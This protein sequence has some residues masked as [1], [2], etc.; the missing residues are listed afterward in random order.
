MLRREAARRHE[1]PKYDNHCRNLTA[2]EIKKKLE[3]GEQYTIRFKL[4]QKEVVFRVANFFQSLKHRV[5]SW[6]GAWQLFCEENH[7]AANIAQW[8]IFEDENFGEITQTN[9]EGDFVLMKSDSFPTYHLAN[10]VDDHWM[11]ISHVIR[12]CE[13]LTSVSKHIQLYE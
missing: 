10:V 7:Y 2:G 8:R 12:G 11:R 3:N 1:V 4:Q 13:W 9:D 6:D 5:K